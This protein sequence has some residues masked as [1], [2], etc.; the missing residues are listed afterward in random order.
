MSMTPFS[1]FR[2]RGRNTVL[3]LLH[4]SS[5]SSDVS[6]SPLT[7]TN[8][9]TR[10]HRRQS[11]SASSRSCMRLERAAP[12]SP[13]ESSARRR[14]IARRS[15]SLFMCSTSMLFSKSF[16]PYALRPGSAAPTESDGKFRAQRRAFRQALNVFS[17]APV[18]RGRSH[19]ENVSEKTSAGKRNCRFHA[20]SVPENTPSAF[21]IR[22]FRRKYNINNLPE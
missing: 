12:S 18:C 7:E 22:P 11:S 17:P 6:G 16:R 2:Q 14:R 5:R 20:D 3:P 4:A 9:A 21:L 10:R 13:L 1:P 19:Y 15:S 8:S